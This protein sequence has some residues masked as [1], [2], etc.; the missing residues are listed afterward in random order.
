LAGRLRRTTTCR[1][2]FAETDQAA[3]P[4]GQQAGGRL[5]RRD[6]ELARPVKALA[7]RHGRRV[8]RA[9]PQARALFTVRMTLLSSSGQGREGGK[10]LQTVPAADDAGQQAWNLSA[11]AA[12]LAASNPSDE[13]TET[14]RQA[15]RAAT[16]IGNPKAK[17]GLA[18]VSNALEAPGEGGEAARVA[19][20]ALRAADAIDDPGRR[21]SALHGV[22]PALAAAKQAGPAL[23]AAMSTTDLAGRDDLLQHVS[24]ELAKNGL[25]EQALESADHIGKHR[26]RMNAL[27]EAAMSLAK[28]GLTEMAVKVTLQAWQAATKVKD[29]KDRGLALS[30]L[31]ALFAMTGRAEM[32]AEAADQALSA[33]EATWMPQRRTSLRWAVWAQAKAGHISRALQVA[34]DSIDYVEEHDR[35]LDAIVTW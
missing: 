19:D 31:A 30:N 29:P 2:A 13:A 24:V 21:D 10:G 34:E 18:I 25:T 17:A 33:A 23:R 8:A 5:G 22:A 20:L 28:D 4:G 11:M 16:G 9:D 1:G 35:A 15:L 27:T 3:V 12:A 26:V 14:A 32:A 7:L 6:Q